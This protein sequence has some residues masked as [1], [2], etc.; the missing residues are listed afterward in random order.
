MSRALFTAKL[1]CWAGLLGLKQ[2][3]CFRPVVNLVV[4]A[5][6]EYRK[7]PT[8]HL[9]VPDALKAILVVFGLNCLDYLVLQCIRRQMAVI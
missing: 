8:L 7:E 1:N 9:Q 2:A 4:W 3:Y 5:V 6:G